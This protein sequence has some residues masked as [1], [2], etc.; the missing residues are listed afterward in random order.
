MKLPDLLG[1]ESSEGF[2]FDVGHGNLDRSDGAL[3]FRRDFNEMPTAV[4]RVPATVGQPSAFEIVQDGH[5]GAGVDR[6]DIDEALLADGTGLVKPAQED[7]MPWAESGGVQR[8]AEAGVHDAPVAGQEE[9]Q[10]LA[11]Y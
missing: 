9:T 2:P 3:A 8:L 4:R 11:C 7:R 6:E 10:L 1:G 5:E